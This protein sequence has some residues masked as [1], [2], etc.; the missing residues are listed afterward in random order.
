[1]AVKWRFLIRL[2]GLTGML[3]AGVGLV[4]LVGL[5]GAGHGISLHWTDL[6]PNLQSLGMKD[7]AVGLVLLGGFL[8]VLALVVEI[9]VGI[10]AIAGQRGAFGFNVI[11]QILLAVVLLAGLNAFSFHHYLRFDWTRDREFTLSSELRT[12]LSEL[13]DKTKIIVLERH[14][15]LGQLGDKPDNYDSAA[16]R[17]VVE[18]VKDLVEQFQEMGPQFEVTVLD[19]QEEGYQDKLDDLTRN[20]KELRS[21]I[22]DAPDNTIFFS[23]NGKVT[24]LGFHDIYQLD[25]QSSQ[26]ANDGRGNLVLLYQGKEPFARKVLNIDEKKPRVALAVIHEILSMEGSEEL[27]MAGVKKTLTA[28]GFDTQD[29]ILKKWSEFAP[30]E[31]AVLTYDE[32]KLER[33]EEELAGLDADIKNLE[34]GLKNLRPLVKLWQNSSL[35]ELT[36]KYADE[37]KGHKLTEEERRV[38]LDRFKQ[39]VALMDFLLIQ[40]K[41]ARDET[42]K[43]KK[44]LSADTL[45]EQRRISD[46]R[47]KT[48]RLLADCD[49]LI[50]PRMTLFNVARGERIPNRVYQ[51]EQSQ[52]EAVRD[53]LKAGKPVLICF[54][55]TN[56]PAG[57][58]DQFN[59]PNDKLEDDLAQLGIKLGK[60]TVL[61]NVESKSFAER[62]GNLMIMGANV[63]VPS[64]EFDWPAGADQIPGQAATVTSTLNPIRESLRLTAR[65]L[66]KN[67]ALDLRIRHPRPVYYIPT[68][69][70]S[71]AYDPTFMMTNTA[72]WNEAQP[73]PTRERTPRYE[74][75][76]SE[77]LAN[78]SVDKSRLGAFPIGVALETTVPKDW[79][80]DKD[81][82][83]AKVRVAAIGQGGVFIG[84]TLPPAKEK[85]LLDVSNWLLGRDDLLTKGND[86]WQY[87]R[88]VLG[89]TQQALWQWGM[90]LGLP[91]LF[92]YLGL[93]VLMVR[94]LR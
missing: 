43:E 53:F 62:R 59:T 3:A 28:R 32:S 16:E 38:N 1:M 26:E 17:K 34:E 44:G 89:D 9:K 80:T 36:K 39:Q 56:E 45:A 51:L 15:A 18:K 72:S 22:D 21:A 10:N 2:L 55:P 48:S 90:R 78:D 31:P 60:Q 12:R 50:I 70:S 65:S 47:A 93:I 35:D 8:A 68:P 84:K 61:F 33:L 11:L 63:E 7:L 79:Y 77:A 40:Q 24:R 4:L 14:V 75:S 92:T 94:R 86:P 25:K 41:E 57:Q 5:A 73:F 85:L 13:R 58:M 83:P 52:V 20:D 54:G 23:A 29:V 69:G 42:L 81:A 76:K 74:P 67:Q 64:V 37:L 66:G 6:A 49:L 27:G 91:I 46:L 71:L 88:V 82:K 30:P 87:P 19:V